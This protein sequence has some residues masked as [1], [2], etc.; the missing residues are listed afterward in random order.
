MALPPGPRLPVAV[1]TL[2]FGLRTIEFFESCERRYGDV[3]TLRLPAGRTL[4]MFSDP[5][6]IR[7]IF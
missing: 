6:A 5:A 7:D 4:V 3:F 1:Q 2:L